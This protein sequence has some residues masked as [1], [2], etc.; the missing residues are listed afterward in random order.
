MKEKALEGK[1]AVIT[2][3]AR[4]IG[5][6]FAARYVAEG[7]KVAIADILIDHR[8]TFA[9]ELLRQRCPKDLEVQFQ[10]GHDHAESNRILNQ[11]VPV[12]IG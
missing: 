10:H 5:R 11:T 1:V 7:A 8:R 3:G 6:A 9:L 2:G 12:I 4:G